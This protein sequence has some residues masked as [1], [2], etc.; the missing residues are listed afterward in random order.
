VAGRQ[1]DAVLVAA[2]V[3]ATGMTPRPSPFWRLHVGPLPA[4]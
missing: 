3:L 1:D 4:Q 2:H